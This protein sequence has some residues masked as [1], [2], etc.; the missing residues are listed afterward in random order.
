MNKHFTI[1]QLCPVCKSS[2]N[3]TLFKL[4]NT[5]SP[6]KEYLDSW[7]FKRIDYSYLEGSNYILDECKDCGLIYQKEILNESTMVKLYDEWIDYANAFERIDSNRDIKHYIPYVSDL[8]NII[9]YLD[10]VPS[11][12]NILDFGM[13]FGNWCHLVKGFGCKVYGVEISQTRIDYTKGIEVISWKDLPNY[14][15]DFI[16]TEQVFEH[17]GDPLGTLLY[18]KQALK[19]NGLIKISVPDGW[20]IKKRLK[21]WDWD[22]L[23]NSKISVNSDVIW[24][25]TLGNGSKNSLNPVAPLQHINCFNRNVLVKMA[26][27]SGL[28]MVMIPNKCTILAM[29]KYEIKNILRSYYY[30]LLNYLLLKSKNIKL[31]NHL[32]LKRKKVKRKGTKLFFK[33]SAL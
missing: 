7:S 26:E 29:D 32:I 22:S 5:E 19:P 2:N 14:Q 31:L 24:Q 23:K 30:L 8:I 18:L 12:L 9:M 20:D 3:I 11:K 21:R 13:G 4:A 27:I 1:R 10:I 16:N 17:L 28:S 6:I 33:K 15:F 25:P